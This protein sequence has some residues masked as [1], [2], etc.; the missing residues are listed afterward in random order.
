MSFNDPIFKK[1]SMKKDY[2]PRTADKNTGV[3]QISIQIN[4]IRD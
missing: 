1:L 4:K 3:Q 2:S